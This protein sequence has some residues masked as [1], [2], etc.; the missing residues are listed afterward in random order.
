M[1]DQVKLFL[2]KKRKKIKKLYYE[3]NYVYN[4]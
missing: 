4:D 1:F 2:V 3:L